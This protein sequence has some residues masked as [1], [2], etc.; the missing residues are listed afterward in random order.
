LMSLATGCKI[1]RSFYFDRK[2]YFYPDLPKGFQISQHFLPIGYNGEIKILSSGEFVPIGISDIHL[3]EDTAKLVHKGGESLIDFNRSGVPLMEIVSMPQIRSAEEAKVYLKRIQQLVR[4]LQISDCDMEKGTM[5]CEANISLAKSSGPIPRNLT[6]LPPYRVEVKN[7]NSFRFVEK[8]IE[9]EIKEQTMMLESGQE[10]KQETKGFD[11]VKGVTYLQR[12]KETASDYRYFPEPDIPCVRVSKV[13][14]K[15]LSAR[16]G[17]L[18]W[19]KE[20]EAID[21]LMLPW[22]TVKILVSDSQKFEQFLAILKEGNKEGVKPIAIANLIVNKR[23]EIQ[24]SPVEI[25]KKIKEGEGQRISG[26]Q[27]SLIVDK[28]IK[29]NPKPVEDVRKG[30]GQAIGFLIG[31]VQR[32]T[33]GAADAREASELI[34]KRLKS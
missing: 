4:N 32:E 29:A 10:P 20:K 25:I 14:Q 27:L 19:E 3:E 30:K 1:N 26:A 23:I 13:K 11:P 22:Q 17:K 28:I 6:K 18:P 16:V 5:R 24:K 12:S 9:F 7:L 8:A 21:G 2:N 31:Q 34:L 33:N 15:E